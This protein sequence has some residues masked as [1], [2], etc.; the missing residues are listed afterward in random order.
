MILLAKEKDIE[1]INLLG[2]LIIDNFDITYNIKNYLKNDNYIILINN[3]ETING[4]LII[5]KN[6]DY[7]EIEIIV[8]KEKYRNKKIATNMLNYFIK[9]YCKK[10]DEILLEV[11][12]KN[13]N[14]IKFYE[15]FNFRTINIRKNYYNNS[16]AYIMKKVIE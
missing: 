4:L 12:E 10:N 9:N 2:K 8:V 11:S 6:V 14:A 1:E 7:Y 16:D 5:Y 3:D 13:Y 15:K